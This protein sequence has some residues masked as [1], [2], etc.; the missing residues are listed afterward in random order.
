MCIYFFTNLPCLWETS[1]VEI[2]IS[3]LEFTENALLGVL[4]DRGELF[5]GSN[6][7]LFTGQK[8]RK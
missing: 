5:V 6:L 2:Q 8:T 4:F 1:I 3:L 7:V